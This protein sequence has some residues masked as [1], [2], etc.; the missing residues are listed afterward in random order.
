MVRIVLAIMGHEDFDHGGRRH[1]QEH[2][3]EA[4]ELGA[5]EQ[6]YQQSTSPTPPPSGRRSVG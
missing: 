1:G 4:E 2:P 3:Q 6:C 5:D